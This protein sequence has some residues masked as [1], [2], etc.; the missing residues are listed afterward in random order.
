MTR[1]EF[2]RMALN[3]ALMVAA[4]AARAQS[5]TGSVHGTVTDP[6]GAVIPSSTITL[7]AADGATRTATSG[8]AGEYTIDQVA[9]GSYT[10]TAT[11]DGFP[12]SEPR[13]VVVSG[14]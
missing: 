7:T 2:L 3:I 11:A 4:L 5:P 6:T 12:G 14:D 9:P 10:A 13:A 8:A 1:H